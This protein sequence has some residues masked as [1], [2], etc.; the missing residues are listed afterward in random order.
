LLWS[1]SFSC[2][3]L[4]VG[5]EIPD[6]LSE[7]RKA[8][9]MFSVAVMDVVTFAGFVVIADDAFAFSPTVEAVLQAVGAVELRFRSCQMTTSTSRPDGYMS[10]FAYI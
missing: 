9:K 2:E 6:K 4:N 7:R 10:F 5:V 8:I 1:W 3:P